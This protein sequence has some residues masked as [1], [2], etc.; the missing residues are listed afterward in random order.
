MTADERR[1]HARYRLWL[2]ARIE[3]EQGPTRVAVGHDVSQGGT[4]LVTRGELTP[5]QSVRLHIR[6]PPTEDG[7]EHVI[8][9]RVLRVD[10]ND[11]DPHGLWPYRVALE[12][13]EP[14]PEIE[15]TLRAHAECVEGVADASEQTD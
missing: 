13:D 1:A 12:F 14:D 4:M 5:G 7:Q 6:I 9:A 3:G 10:A 11:A 15:A 8:A 2:P